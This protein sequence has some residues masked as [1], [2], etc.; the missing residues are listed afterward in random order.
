MK[1]VGMVVLFLGIVTAT[2]AA[3]GDTTTVDVVSIQGNAQYRVGSSQWVG[4]E[5]GMELPVNA[6][7]VTSARSRVILDIAGNDVTVGSL[8]R[9]L[10][11]ELTV[12]EREVTTRLD[13]PYGRLSAS[14]RSSRNRGNDFSIESPIATA[15]VRGT[16][17]DFSGY[18]LDVAHGDVELANTI[19]QTHSVREGQLSRSFGVEGIQ[20]VEL[21]LQ[22]ET[23]LR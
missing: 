15:A 1:K 13:L 23:M 2:W 11:D 22:E 8:T 18:E 3:T 19:G 20:S 9:L 21:T 7:I 16:E 12:Q 5:R 4:M 14:V 10:I 17:F 6:E